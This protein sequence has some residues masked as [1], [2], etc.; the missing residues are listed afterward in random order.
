MQEWIEVGSL[1]ELRKREVMVVKGA[2][3]PIAVFVDGETIAAVDNRCPHMGFPLNRG[4]VRDGILT[5]HWHHAR[6]D[7]CNGCAFDLFADDVPSFETEL[8]EGNVWVCNVPRQPLDLTAHRAR[9]RRGLEHNLPLTQAKSLLGLLSGNAALETFVEEV[10]TYGAT[11]RMTW[12]PGLTW[13][14]AVGN[15]WPHLDDET[16]TLAAAQGVRQVAADCAGQPMRHQL[17]A[18]EGPLQDKS[19]FA[20]WLAHWVQVRHRDGAER[21]LL[22]AMRSGMASHELAALL[23][24]AA[25]ERP[26]ADGGHLLDFCNKSC[27]LLD[28]IGWEKADSILPL[29]ASQLAAARG[30][31]E[32]T[33]WRYPHDLVIL[34]QQSQTTL[35]D[36]LAQGKEKPAYAQ[37]DLLQLSET[38][39]GDDP[40]ALIRA[41]LD[42]LQNGATPA[43]LAQAVA[44]AAAWRNAHFA[45]SNELSDWFTSMHTMTY[46]NATWRLMERLGENAKAVHV[47]AVLHG[48]FQ[49]YLDRFLNVPPAALPQPQS[50]QETD[51]SWHDAILQALDGRQGELA[52][53]LVAGAQQDGVPLPRLWGILAQ[54]TQREDLDFHATQILEACLQ[55][56]LLWP[57]DEALFLTAT[58]RYLAAHCPTPRARL[59]TIQV[60]MRLHRGDAIYEEDTGHEPRQ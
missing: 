29:L 14:A 18:A 15:L 16:K 23:A 5:C 12:G 53:N 7:L 46:T 41:I 22:E 20:R 26:F 32:S 31:E 4:S 27:E 37:S 1:E 13:L 35:E 2:Q 39:L 57:G 19:T 36:V 56:S 55:Q 30:A 24:G 58:T 59:Q 60:A 51:Q 49:V 8:R 17:S 33:A 28:I 21:T 34:L 25:T 42:A 6:F 43:Q 3:C 10:A 9:L 50:P 44:R 54:A 40:D 48:A 38:L 11:H 47:R 45:S 52:S